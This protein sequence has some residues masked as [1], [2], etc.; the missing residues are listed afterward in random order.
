MTSGVWISSRWTAA[1]KVLPDYAHYVWKSN[2]IT[3]EKIKVSHPI[4][5]ILM[6]SA[7]SS[8][9][10]PLAWDIQTKCNFSSFYSYQICIDVN[11]NANICILILSLEKL[12]ESFE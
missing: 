9:E 10:G 6:T 8:T 4:F 12:Y 5:A 11:Q 1:F 7:N 2:V 3:N